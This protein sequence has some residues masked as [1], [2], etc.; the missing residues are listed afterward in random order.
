[1]GDER[2]N[3]S[4]AAVTE[5]AATGANFVAAWNPA[6]KESFVNNNNKY[7]VKIIK[8]DKTTATGAVEVTEVYANFET[9]GKTVLAS[10]FTAGL[11]GHEVSYKVAYKYDN[12]TIPQNDIPQV[13]AKME[14]IELA[15][16]A[17]RLAIYYSQ[18]AA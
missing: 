13:T 9:D 6:V 1:M 2:I 8:T 4:G 15:A 7:D 11:E 17:R 5:A 12:V 3:Y 14:G 16:K 10:N 18:M